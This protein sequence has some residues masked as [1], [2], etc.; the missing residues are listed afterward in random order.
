MSGGRKGSYRRKRMALLFLTGMMI[1]GGAT[2][3]DQIGKG[4][5]KAEQLDSLNAELA[6]ATQANDDYKREVARLNDKEYLEQK[7]RSELHYAYPGET[8]FYVPK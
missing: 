6:K 4:D 3:W 7:I 8:I 2:L 1:W 5:V